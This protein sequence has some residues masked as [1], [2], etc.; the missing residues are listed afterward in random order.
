MGYTQ[1]LDM[2]HCQIYLAQHLFA[3]VRVGIERKRRM[4]REGEGR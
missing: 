4:T 2:D 1:D 3:R